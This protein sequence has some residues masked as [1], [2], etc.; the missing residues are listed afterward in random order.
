MFATSDNPRSEDPRAILAEI[1]PALKA[2]G[3][4]Y[5]VEPDRADAIVWRSAKRGP[6]MWFCSP[7]KDTRRNRFSPTAP[8]HSTTRK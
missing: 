8:F 2:S 4:R 3:V 6:A 1:E 7:A 5:I